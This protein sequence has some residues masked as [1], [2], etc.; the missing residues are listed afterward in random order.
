MDD[1]RERL[2]QLRAVSQAEQNRAAHEREVAEL[3]AAYEA[4]TADERRSDLQARRLDVMTRILVHLGVKDALKALRAQPVAKGYR[5]PITS[6]NVELNYVKIVLSRTTRRIIPNYR[7]ETRQVG[8]RAFE[9]G[10]VYVEVATF[11]KHGRVWKISPLHMPLAY[12]PENQTAIQT[13][14]GTALL[15]WVERAMQ[16]E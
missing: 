10:Q 15:T 8:V 1:F 3:V 11:V 2:A 9:T 13:M 14:I 12:T 6:R 5:G 16:G 4:R 7:V